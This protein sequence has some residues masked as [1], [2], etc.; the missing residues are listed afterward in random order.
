MNKTI[1]VRTGEDLD[2]SVVN[3]VMKENIEGLVGSPQIRQFA[4]GHSNLTYSLDYGTRKFV[5]RRPPF[6]TK[7]KSG[8]SMIREY[9]VMKA[10]KPAFGAVPECFFHMD[11]DTSPFGAEF[12]VMEQVEGRK[13]EKEIPKD[14]GF[15]HQE[16]RKLCL[17]FFEKLIDLHKVDYKAIGLGDFGKPEGYVERQIKGWN[18]RYERALT[19]DVDAF[20][21]VRDWLENVMPETE[22]GHSICHGD[23]RLDNVILNGEDPY[24]IDAVLDWEISALGDPMM[25]L[26]NTLAYWVQA[27]DPD[28]LKVAAMQPSQ[29][30]GM[31][32]REEIVELYGEAT[33]FDMSKF[34]FY[35]VYG[36]FRLVV[37]LQQ[38]YYRYYHGQTK[39]KAF[40]SFGMQVNGFG[41]YA[42]YLIQKSKL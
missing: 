13:L 25:D 8:H 2:V 35:H 11:D 21:D 40:A 23:F 38:I 41:N 22:V 34:T 28:T 9:S 33:G 3:K 27:D 37:I 16:G 5:L 7:P 36:V 32:T 39:N 15:G 30:E 20:E 10:L 12:Y 4:S 19:D 6:G 24:K 1:D 29:A 14:W 42:R 31:M 17:S 26:G 18:G